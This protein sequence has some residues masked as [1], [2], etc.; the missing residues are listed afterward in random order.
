MLQVLIIITDLFMQQRFHFHHIISASGIFIMQL[1]DYVVNSFGFAEIFGH[2]LLPTKFR[3]GECGCRD[4]RELEVSG[5]RFPSKHSK[6]SVNLVADNLRACRA[7][8]GSANV[9]LTVLGD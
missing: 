2:W 5:T 9:L 8:V 3:K 4:I 7:Q 6:I 1:R